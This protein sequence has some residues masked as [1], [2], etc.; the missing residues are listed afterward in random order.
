[1]RR[2]L[3]LLLVLLAAFAALVW[4]GNIGLGPVLITR[5]DEQKIVTLFGSP[6]TVTREPGIALRLPLLTDVLVFDKRRLYLNTEPLLIPMRDQE[7]IVVD[8]YVVWRITDPVAFYSSFPK[9]RSD[10]ETLIDRIVGADL[11]EVI[12]QRTLSE[13]VTTSR[14]E[15]MNEVTKK[16]DEELRSAGI[17]IDDV[18]INRTELPQGTEANVFARMRTERERLARKTRA[19]GE[20][21]GRRVRAEADREA[22]VIVAEA[23]RDA[24][25]E[26]GV[27]DAEA[28]RI[29]A[30]AYSV[31]PDFYGFVRSLEAYRKAIGPGTTLVLSPKSEFFRVLDSA[32]ENK[33]P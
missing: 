30:E 1:V 8:T 24:Q 12:G 14:V 6:V 7:R 13:V 3:F 11:R 32:R 18:R 16:S 27:G 23:E 31:Q 25:I 10:A 4:A 28:A 29:F 2:V 20:E 21:E 15:I 33:G 17:A 9:G 22:Q 5:E 19:E 26:R